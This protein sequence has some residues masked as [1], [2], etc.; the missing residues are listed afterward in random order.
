ME[1]LKKIL[2]YAL[3]ILALL[4]A[5]GVYLQKNGTTSLP[6]VNRTVQQKTADGEVDFN[7]YGQ[8][9]EFVGIAKWLNSE[10]LTIERLEG[11]VV[12][13]DFW[14]YSC[15][16]CIR[17]LPYITKL[18]DTYKD[19]GLVVIGMH[20]PEFA[21]EKVTANVETAIERH[22]INYPVAQDND[23]KTWEAYNNRYWPAHYL[24]NQQGEIVYMHFGE[25]S[26]DVT[27]KAVQQLL[28]LDTAKQV[29][30]QSPEFMRIKSP[31]MYFGTDR[32]E[33]L[34]SS[35]LPY[36]GREYNYKL[37]GQELALNTFALEGSWAF[38][39]EFAALAPGSESSGKIKLRFNA[40]KVHIVAGSEGAPVILKVKVD[41]QEAGEVKIDEMKLYTVFDSEDYG[42]HVLEISTP[43]SGN[44]QVFTFTFG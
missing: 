14:T 9:P 21:F 31:E 29:N 5:G 39:P 26:Y 23:Y 7:N 33:N 3:V 1:T 37:P 20:T 13:V 16:N 6:L 44:L 30:A 28:N 22:K 19:K 36:I 41:G 18:Y 27:E 40:G 2:P 10:P 12:L 42:E 24:I 32:L 17:T 11:K 8:A 43:V 38:T 35:Q 4:I 15:I 34:A 25:G